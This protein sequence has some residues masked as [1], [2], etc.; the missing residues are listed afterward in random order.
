M[1]A[2]KITTHS[3][4]Q[5]QQ[6]GK[7]VV[8]KYT[9][10]LGQQPI[11]FALQGELGTGK[12]QFVKGLAQGLGISQ[13]IT[14]PSYALVNEY[15]STHQDQTFPFVHIDAWRLP[16][17]DDLESLGWTRFLQENAVIALE[18]A[19]WPKLVSE[20]NSILVPLQ[21]AYEAATDDRTII[22]GNPEG[23]NL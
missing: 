15:T 17:A 12:T 19:H 6:L 18:W 4:V 3:A 8:Q 13:L 20:K 14:S 23:K 21:F 5:T 10:F 16:S 22:I 11:I 9:S 2:Q 1:P 7:N